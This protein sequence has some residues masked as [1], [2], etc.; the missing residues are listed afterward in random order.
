MERVPGTKDAQ[1]FAMKDNRGER[2]GLTVDIWKHIAEPMPFVLCA[3][4][5]KLHV[6]PSQNRRG[7]DGGRADPRRCECSR[8]ACS[9]LV[10]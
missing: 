10:K 4:L 9:K 8:I 2:I 6:K 5:T 7:S 1:S 3:W